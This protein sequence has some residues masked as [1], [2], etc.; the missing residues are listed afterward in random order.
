MEQKGSINV[1]PKIFEPVT[2][3][4]EKSTGFDGEIE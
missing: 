1:D 3:F 4:Y 2:R